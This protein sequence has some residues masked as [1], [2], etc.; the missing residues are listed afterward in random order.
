MQVRVLNTKVN[1]APETTTCA[2]RGPSN[3]SLVT[4]IPKDTLWTAGLGKG[5]DTRPTSNTS[6]CA[7]SNTRSEMLLCAGGMR[8]DQR[9]SNPALL[10]I[11]GTELGQSCWW[12]LPPLGAA[13]LIRGHLP[14]LT[15]LQNLERSI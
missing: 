9:A 14:K 10:P 5:A 4:L 8:P 7:S 13:F 12:A 3:R 2:P 15:L 6:N 11:A 1:A